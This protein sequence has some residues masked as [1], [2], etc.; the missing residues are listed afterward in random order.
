[1]FYLAG[2]LFSNPTPLPFVPPHD[3]SNHD[4]GHSVDGVVSTQTFVPRQTK[5]IRILATSFAVKSRAA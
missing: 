3:S 1:M 2:C 5:V 4:A